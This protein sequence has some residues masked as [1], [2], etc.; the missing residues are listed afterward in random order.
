MSLLECHISSGYETTSAT[1]SF[2]SY[3]LVKYPEVQ[4]KVIKE[5]DD[6]LARHGGNVEHET[7]GELVYLSACFQETLR[8]F[9]SLIRIERKCTKE[10]RH[11]SGLVIPE[12]MIVEIP[13]FS[14]HEDPEY[15]PDPHIFKPERFLPEN[16]DNLNPYSYLPFGLGNHNCIGMRMS[17]E[18]SLIAMVKILKIFKFRAAANTNIV[19]KK[20]S[21]FAFQTEPFSVE[22]V[23]RA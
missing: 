6:Y 10:W 2:L 21:T 5:V 15:F 11:E 20:G 19:V 9:P 7:L 17:K 13:V 22:A 16:K 18:N 3:L 23:K 1:L 4:D 12:G 14:L 8:I